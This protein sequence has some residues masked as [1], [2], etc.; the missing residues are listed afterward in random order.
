MGAKFAS[1]H[2]Y[3][4]EKKMTDEQFETAYLD[5]LHDIEKELQK[6]CVTFHN[7]F[8]EIVTQ[9]TKDKLRGIVAAEHDEVI[10]STSGDWHSAFDRNYTFETIEDAA[11]SVSQI[12]DQPVFFA[13]LYD[14]DIFMFGVCRE[15]RRVTRQIQIGFFASR[16]YGIKREAADAKAFCQ[17]LNLKNT[18]FVEKLCKQKNHR[19][20]IEMIERLL[21]ISIWEV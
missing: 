5:E 8:G 2:V 14:D 1:I 20:S 4:S 17:Q 9:E 13:T 6:R 21:G 12:V 3:D 16:A 11:L 18:S 7:L 10:F 15:G 19:R